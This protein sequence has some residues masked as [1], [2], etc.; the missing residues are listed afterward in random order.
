MKKILLLFVVLIVLSAT[1]SMA[2]QKV[3][4]KTN[5]GV[6]ELE[7]DAEKAPITVRNFMEYVDQKF[8]NDTIFHRVIGNFMIQGGGFDTNQ[9]RKK[10]L[11][12]IKNEATNGLKNYKGTIAMARTSVVDSA[13]SQFFINLVDNHRLDN[14]GISAQQY[15]YTVFGR[16]SAGMDVV[17]KIGRVKTIATS[18]MF[19]DIPENPVIIEEI[20]RID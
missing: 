7:L 12:A 13:T 11:P 5:Y 9:Q 1:L 16:V 18:R 15:G 20:I 3:A 19:R 4:M 2:G 17:E 14:S 8:Y 6:I 10:T